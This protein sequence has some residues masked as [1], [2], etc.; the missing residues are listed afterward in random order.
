MVSPSSTVPFVIMTAL[1]QVVFAYNL[2]Q[3]LRGAKHVERRT[4]LRSVGFT[5]SL[6]ATAG[7]LAA[8]AFAVDHKDA[9]ET[10]AKPALGAAGG[11]TANVGAQ[12]F[13]SRCGSCHTLKA[14]NTTGTIGPDLDQLKPDAA[15]VLAALR[16]GGTGSGTMPKDLVVGAEAQQ[17]AKFVA[18]NAGR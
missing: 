1:G 17:V 6:L 3:T 5:A 15:R 16:N 11:G 12:L 2:I 14:A 7:F 9:G 8:A 10:P 18:T 13:S 4:A